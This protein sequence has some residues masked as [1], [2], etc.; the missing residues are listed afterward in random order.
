MVDYHHGA[1]VL[2]IND[3]MRPLSTVSTI[4]AGLVCTA[5]NADAAAFPLNT[6]VLIT[7]ILAAAG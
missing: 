7:K 4:I 3:G 6:P 2:E 1:R 5:G